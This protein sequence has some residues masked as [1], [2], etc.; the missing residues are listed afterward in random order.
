MKETKSQAQNPGR[1]I[2]IAF[3]MIGPCVGLWSRREWGRLCGI[4]MSR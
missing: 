2:L 1:E 4:G 3:K